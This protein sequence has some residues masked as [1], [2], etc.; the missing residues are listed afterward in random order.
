MQSCLIQPLSAQEVLHC[1]HNDGPS[2]HFCYSTINFFYCHQVNNFLY[3]NKLGLTQQH[4]FFVE[5]TSHFLGARGTPPVAGEINCA[6]RWVGWMAGSDCAQ[7][8][9]ALTSPHRGCPAPPAASTLLCKP[10][11]CAQR[12]FVISFLVCALISMF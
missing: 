9:A 7:C 3:N 2:C 1:H 6:L 11:I 5:H 8:E 10:S 12:G 4:Q